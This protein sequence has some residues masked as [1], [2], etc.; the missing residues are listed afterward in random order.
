MDYENR[1]LK[2]LNCSQPFVFSA[3]EQRFFALKGYRNDPK[4][5]KAC[6][7]ERNKAKRRPHFAET[8]VN[9]AECGRK[10][11]VP[12][13]PSGTKPVL[14]SECFQRKRKKFAGGPRLVHSSDVRKPSDTRAGDDEH[15]GPRIVRDSID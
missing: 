4:R 10:T 5:C 6:Q 7:M 1:T 11:T 12:F 14:C 2:C 9:C 8:T 15:K 3:D 13:V